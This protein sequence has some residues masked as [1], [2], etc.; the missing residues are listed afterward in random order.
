MDSDKDELYGCEK[1][2]ILENGE[3][4]TYNTLEIIYSQLNLPF[5]IAATVLDVTEVISSGKSF[6]G[7][8]ERVGEKRLILPYEI[9]EPDQTSRDLRDILKHEQKGRYA[10][11]RVDIDDEALSL[12][13]IARPYFETVKEIAKELNG[14]PTQEEIFIYGLAVVNAFRN[15]YIEG[16]KIESVIDSKEDKSKRRNKMQ[17]KFRADLFFKKLKEE[18]KKDQELKKWLTQSLPEISKLK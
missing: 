1:Y 8:K 4:R 18:Y 10:S 3:A 11:R 12:L 14:P 15:L 13:A 7:V 6:L 9:D 17:I 5:V 2:V 16:Y